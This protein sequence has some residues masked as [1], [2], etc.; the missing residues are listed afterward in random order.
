MAIKIVSSWRGGLQL[1]Y[2]A[3]I[4]G[5]RLSDVNGAVRKFASHGAASAAAIQF[6]LDEHAARSAA[7][8]VASNVQDSALAQ[9]V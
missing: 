5:R 7:D 4:D 9:T 2:F 8:A 6:V 1:P 3:V